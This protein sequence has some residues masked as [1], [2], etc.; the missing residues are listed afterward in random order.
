MGL[1]TPV[2][3]SDIPENLY[4]V[5]DT[6]LSFKHGDIDDLA[7]VL[8]YALDSPAVLQDNARRARER[9]EH[10]FNWEAVADQ[11]ARLFTMGTLGDESPAQRQCVGE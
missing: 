6:A 8:R 10:A 2:I 7:R 1:G 4:A 3:C 9:A 11:H 5:R